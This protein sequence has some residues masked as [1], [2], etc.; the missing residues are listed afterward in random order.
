MAIVYMV[1]T[2]KGSIICANG[3]MYKP[4]F[5]GPGGYKPRTWKTIE[6]AKRYA[7]RFGG[8][9]VQVR[10]DGEI[11][12]YLPVPLKPIDDRVGARG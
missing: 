10:E 3:D 12:G 4:C 7:E 6:G 1:Q 11:G 5:V 9:I 2:E 8:W